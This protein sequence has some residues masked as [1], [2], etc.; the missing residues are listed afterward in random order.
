MGFFLITGMLFLSL[1]QSNI[2]HMYLEYVLQPV[3]SMM[4]N[5]VISESWIISGPNFKANLKGNFFL[6][7]SKTKLFTMKCYFLV[8][9]NMISS[10]S[11][12]L[13]GLYSW[14]KELICTEKRNPIREINIGWY[15]CQHFS[16]PS[17]CIF[18]SLT[19]SVVFKTSVNRF[20]ILHTFRSIFSSL[21]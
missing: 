11:E 17:L 12:L 4:C 19:I 1:Q 18:S 8:V 6:H 20:Y 5:H 7:W 2:T 14:I 13:K 21:R 16:M 9:Q 3:Y 15:K 10:W